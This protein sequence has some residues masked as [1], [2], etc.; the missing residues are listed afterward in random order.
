M[1]DTLNGD[2][3]MSASE[4]PASDDATSLSGE[5]M[6]ISFLSSSL[7]EKQKF[8]DLVIKRLK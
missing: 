8:L 2:D 6:V 4:R 7:G 1:G 3:L 5:M